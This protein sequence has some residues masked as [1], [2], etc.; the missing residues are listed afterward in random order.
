MSLAAFVGSVGSFQRVQEFLSTDIRIDSR[1]K[2]EPMNFPLHARHKISQNML[3]S[4][5]QLSSWSTEKS[6]LT[7]T[8]HEVELLSDLTAIFV[9]KGSFGWDKEKEPLLQSINM[10]V[11]KEKMTMLVGPVGCGKSTLIKALL[12]E[13]STMAG[14]I[15]V[16]SLGIAFCD[17]TPWH[18]NGSIRQSIIGV[19]EFEELW[20][21][22]VVHACALDEDLRQLSKGDQTVIGSNGIALSGGQSQR[23][24]SLQLSMILR[25]LY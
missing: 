2:P 7:V 6:T 18:M 24:V 25:I 9:Q 14:T 20:Y 11:P 1:M 4:S 22:T 21:T 12:G 15:Q 10:I 16:S 8:P 5:S 3:T 13:A 17:Q 23:I 19:S